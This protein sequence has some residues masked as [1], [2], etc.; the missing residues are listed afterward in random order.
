MQ[1]AG[2]YHPRKRWISMLAATPLDLFAYANGTDC[3][4]PL[5]DLLECYVADV[6]LLPV[7]VIKM[8][9]FGF[10]DSEALGFHRGA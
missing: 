8:P 2:Q 1:F 9:P 10:V 4:S 5:L 3:I 7:L 6:I